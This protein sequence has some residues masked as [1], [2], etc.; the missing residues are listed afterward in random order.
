MAGTSMSVVLVAPKDEPVVVT[1]VTEKPHSGWSPIVV[2]VG[3]GVT[4]VAAG[5]LIWSG[6][7]TMNQRST[8]DASPTQANLDAGKGD[9]LRTNVLLGVTLGLAVL[10]GV[11]AIFLVDWKPHKTEHARVFVGPMG[12]WGT[13]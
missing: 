9:Q 7:D 6:I 1:P 2:A 5:F 11:T 13:F 3:G 4:A 8:F 12:A 10:T